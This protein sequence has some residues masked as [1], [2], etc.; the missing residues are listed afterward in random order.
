MADNKDLDL[1]EF[2][3]TGRNRHGYPKAF[4]VQDDGTLRGWNVGVGVDANTVEQPL[5][6]E[7]GRQG[8][9]VLWG[10]GPADLERVA[11]QDL[12]AGAY[13][14]INVPLGWDG[15]TFPIF[16][17]ENAAS[18][19]VGAQKVVLYGKDSAGPVAE[20]LLTSP[21]LVVYNEPRNPGEY[22]SPDDMPVADATYYTN[23]NTGFLVDVEI[24]VVNQSGAA[25]TV[26]VDVV[27]SGGAVG[28]D[29]RI[30]AAVPVIP[31]SVGI[32]VGAYT[33]NV[34]GTVHG[35]CSIADACTIHV[36]VL[37]LRRITP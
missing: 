20:A 7:A 10:E 23:N 35:L 33:L 31:A 29:R 25:A 9:T 16:A 21:E 22:V 37:R 8:A 27:E 34:G 19:E 13:G 18:G 4:F 6:A 28:V 1:L 24:E 12:G 2:F 30:L 17:V 26:T 32:R 11:L 14:L 36:H 3:P 15:A 5:L